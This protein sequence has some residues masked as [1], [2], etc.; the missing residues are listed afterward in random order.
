MK[1]FQKEYPRLPARP[2]ERVGLKAR[3]YLLSSLFFMYY[4]YYQVGRSSVFDVI[5]LLVLFSIY[6]YDVY[7]FRITYMDVARGDIAETNDVYHFP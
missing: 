7:T 1:T 5:I 4:N 3:V 6:Y 2:T